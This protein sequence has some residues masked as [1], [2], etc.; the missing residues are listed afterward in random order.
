VQTIVIIR[1]SSRRGPESAEA[2]ATWRRRR[3]PRPA[4]VPRAPPCVLFTGDVC[5]PTH[6]WRHTYPSAVALY[7]SRSPGY[8]CRPTSAACGSPKLQR[9]N[10]LSSNASV[11]GQCESS[12]PRQ[13]G[14]PG[15]VRPRP[16]RRVWKPGRR[17]RRHGHNWNRW[18]GHG[19][20][21]YRHWRRHGWA[22]PAH[23]GGAQDRRHPAPLRQLQ[24]ELGKFLQF[25]YSGTKLVRVATSTH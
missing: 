4:H 9:D 15:T 8:K 18:Y 17:N 22:V 5:R 21:W 20:T 13:H 19:N 16:R 6:S 12:N 25:N 24:L 23:E 14:A 10:P 1:F 7:G 2:P 11:S 3:A